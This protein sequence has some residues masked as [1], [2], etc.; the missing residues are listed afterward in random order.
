[1]SYL[2]KIFYRQ[3]PESETWLATFTAIKDQENKMPKGFFHTFTHFY[4]HWNTSTHTLK[5]T[6]TGEGG[7]IRW[8]CRLERLVDERDQRRM[9][10]PLW[11]CDRKSIVSKIII[12]YNH[13]EQKRISESTT[14]QISFLSCQQGTRSC[15]IHEHWLI[16]RL[17]DIFFN[18]HLSSFQSV[19]DKYSTV[20][21]REMSHMKKHVTP[22]TFYM[23]I[24]WLHTPELPVPSL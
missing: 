20:Y 7:S 13:D 17:S 8:V 14:H 9:T 2:I 10:R 24:I 23:C 19:C 16:K 11:W 1:M 4:F 6:H 21:L 22:C 15:S 5:I 3:R 12:I 18:I